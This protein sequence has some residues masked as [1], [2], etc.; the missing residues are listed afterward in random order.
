[1]EHKLIGRILAEKGIINEEALQK[2]LD[3]Q[4]HSKERLG[5]ILLRLGAITEDD[6]LNALSLQLGIPRI[7][8]NDFPKIPPVIEPH[9]SLKFLK[10]YMIVPVDKKDNMVIAA[11]ADPLDFF[12]IDAIQ[13]STGLLVEPRI[14]SEKDII[15]AIDNYYAKGAATMEKIIGTMEEKEGEK[16]AW[17]IEDDVEHLKDMA[18]EAPI[19]NLVN[20]VI[21]QAIEKKASDIHIEPFEDKLNIRYRIDGILHHIDSP[22]KQLHPAIASRIKIMSKLNIAE[23]RL[24]QD[25]RIKTRILDKDID[26]RV[27][28]V[29]TLYGE[30]IVMRLLDSSSI[31]GL[32]ELGFSPNTRSEFERMIK[33]P[34]GMLLVTGPTG[35]GKTTT[36]YAAIGMTD[37][38]QKKVIT[39]EDPIEYYL[40]AINQIQVKP[41]IGLT[42]A[43][44]LRS[45]VRQ[46]PDVIMVG[47]IRDLE[48][49][50]ISIH[51]A[52][53][54]HLV[55]STLHTNDAA[56]AVTRLMDMGIESYL[57]SS[58]LIG[59]LAQRLVRVI[60][61][62]CK[63]P[64]PPDAETMKI[65]GI[66][67]PHFKIYKGVGCD[68]C[69]NTGYKGRTGI[70]E[71]MPVHD[72]IR[73]LIVEKKGSN[74]I[75]RKAIELG[76]KTLRED[77]WEKVRHGITT[78]EEVVRVT[79]EEER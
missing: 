31:I 2:A 14:C 30:S 6:M 43:N 28:A 4:K 57:I 47:E 64:V 15:S 65:L 74:I 42:F 32:K 48:T 49:A 34:Y 18:Q 54:G 69:G 38:S 16:P 55:F 73:L 29:P 50:D 7:S 66:D 17:E 62:N 51:A 53:T 76:M 33:T 24:P 36:L 77:G 26:I 75:K 21:A 79:Q 40:D 27:S 1:M 23:R 44:G 56:G 10:Q 61:N 58:S 22:P 45:I 70:F 60:C 39:I 71:L 12:A 8:L 5:S 67:K 11:M 25:G 3:E 19:I 9:L 46:D 59:V 78:M 68:A 41:K 37:K 20:L 52:L 72:E 63:M 13:I 35:S